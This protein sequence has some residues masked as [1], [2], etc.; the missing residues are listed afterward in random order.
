M[1][2]AQALTH[3]NA[4]GLRAIAQQACM[5][6]FVWA[7]LLRLGPRAPKHRSA[8]PA[9]AARP[10]ASD[11]VIILHR[12]CRRAPPP[13]PTTA[14]V[15]GGLSRKRRYTQCST[16]ALDGSW[17]LGA[18]DALTGETQ[19]TLEGG[20]TRQRRGLKY[21]RARTAG[22][23]QR[24]WR[25]RTTEGTSYKTPTRQGAAG[26]RRMCALIHASMHN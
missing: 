14:W 17:Q 9:W 16:S 3:P 8:T 22:R 15:V 13:P 24:G 23:S 5:S 11:S 10:E 12:A 19:K 26:R 6:S 4:A 1:P 25:T 21:V 20:Y 2:F 18:G 7:L